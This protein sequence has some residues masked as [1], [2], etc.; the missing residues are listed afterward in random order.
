MVYNYPRVDVPLFL[1][2]AG[3]LR[4]SRATASIESAAIRWEWSRDPP[5]EQ[6]TVT[7]PDDEATTA[8]FVRLRD[9]DIPGKMVYVGKYI[10]LLASTATGDRASLLGHVRAAHGA[11]GLV[12]NRWHTLVLGDDATPR[13]VWE[14]W[15]YGFVLHD[16]QDKRERYAALDTLRQGMVRW[17]SHVYAA[18]VYHVVTVVD[19]MLRD[20]ELD[21]ERV[22]T[23]FWGTRPEFRDMLPPEEVFMKPVTKLLGD[24]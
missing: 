16:D 9:F 11:V 10:D 1:E 17:I 2:R 8:F 14:L 23:A 6:V 22:Q 7:G 24:E 12:P 3:T 15:T 13:Q 20:P 4:S 18:D 21:L 5:S 19:A